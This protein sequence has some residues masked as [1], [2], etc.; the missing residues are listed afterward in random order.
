M[1]WKGRMKLDTS[2]GFTEQ[3]GSRNNYRLPFAYDRGGNVFLK[4]VE[5]PLHVMDGT[6]LLGPGTLI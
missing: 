5:A 3:W 6:W 2:L 1:K 4:I